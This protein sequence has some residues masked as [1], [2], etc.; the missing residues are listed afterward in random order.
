[1]IVNSSSSLSRLQ[2]TYN[3]KENVEVPQ[4]DLT[5]YNSCASILKGA[6][7]V[8]HINPNLPKEA[9]IG[10]NMVSAAVAEKRKPDSKFQHFVLSTVF[11][12]QISKM[13]NHAR[14]LKLEGYLIDCAA[15]NTGALNWT[16]IQ[17][18]HLAEA[19]IGRL[20]AAVKDNPGNDKIP[21]QNQFDVEVPF[22]FLSLRDLGKAS[23]K[24]IQEHS[25]HY[26]ATYGL[27]STL[28][29]R[30]KDFIQQIG[31]RLNVQPDITVLPHEKAVDA[32]YISAFGTTNV[33][34]ATQDGPERLV[35]YYKKRG[36]LGNPN[37][38][39]WLLGRAPT[40]VADMVD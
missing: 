35:L 34:Q 27:S 30:Y 21:F 15:P 26:F 22:S 36:L 13:L 1:M 37:V 29:M 23:A 3:G 12:T 25:S 28:P 4:A 24:V 18:G 6:T 33:D 38:C 14:K 17:P 7:T 40:S 16:I 19:L 2:D 39:S 32:N 31:T 20:V 10:I 11:C 8:Y 5:D 9:E